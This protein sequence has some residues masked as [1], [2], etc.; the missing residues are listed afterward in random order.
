M[1]RKLSLPQVIRRRWWLG[2]VAV[3]LVALALVVR[4]LTAPL[5]VSAS[6]G[7]GDRQVPRTSAIDLRFTHDMNA[8]SVE[9]ALSIEP[10]VPL[11]VKAR[12][13]RQFEI[14]PKMQADTAYRLQLKGARAA[15]GRGEVNYSLRFKT[16]PA[17]QVTAVTLNQAKVADGQQAVPL[18]GKLALTFSQAMDSAKTPLFLD[19]QP[20]D[21]KRIKWVDDGKSLTTEL[22][23]GH[24]R[25]YAL[26]IPQTAVN[27]RQD[28]LQADWKFSFTTLIQVP[29]AGIPDRIGSGAPA[30][31]QIENS[32]DAR[33][34]WGIQQADIVYE[35]ISEGSVPR[36]S[37][38][39]WHPL[40]E[41]VGPVRSC[42]LITLA[43]QQMYKGM[44]YC[45]GANDYILG[46]IWGPPLP[47]LIND[48]SR[49]A[50]GVFFR[51]GSRYPPSN[52]LMH[53]NNATTFTG[54]QN[55]PA[56]NYL[57]MPKHDDI[58]RTGDPAPQIV[59]PDQDTVWK[60]DPGSKQYLK[61]QDGAPLNNVG[62]GQVHAKT[63]IVEHVTSYLDKDPRNVFHGYYTEYYEL[64]GEGNA[65]I[66][67]GGVVVHARWRHSDPNVPAAYYTAD[68]EPIELDTGLTWV[69]VIGSEKWR[70]GL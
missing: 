33:P 65:D 55:L 59:V 60:Y 15:S 10:T 4:A 57:I 41:L 64:K 19:G 40:P 67:T 23:L 36:L 32:L 68:G 22:K 18:Q 12:S 34:Q 6:V 51:E 31:I 50:G 24:S 39:Y 58:P 16:E 38:L 53:G 7:D 46:K 42:R 43:V 63:V 11:S 8:A 13:K 44:I 14:R 45:S 30:L 2:G 25:Q 62:T 69:H 61:W 47:S 37:A 27:R 70:G 9:Q 52:V 48:Y 54:A 17:P 26:S 21:S 29:S 66:F 3:G 1:K 5:E 20:V 28:P 49:G 56:P 35:Y